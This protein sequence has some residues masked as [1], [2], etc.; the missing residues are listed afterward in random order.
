MK[1]NKFNKFNKFSTALKPSYKSKHF[2]GC[3]LLIGITA[4]ISNMFTM[5]AV[6]EILALVQD[7][8][9]GALPISTADDNQ[10]TIEKPQGPVNIDSKEIS[11]AEDGK[12]SPSCTVSKTTTSKDLFQSNSFQG[13]SEFVSVFCLVDFLCNF[14]GMT[15]PSS[16]ISTQLLDRIV[17]ALPKPILKQLP[18]FFRN[19]AHF[20]GEDVL[21]PPLDSSLPENNQIQVYDRVEI[22][23]SLN[24]IIGPRET[25]ASRV[26]VILIVGL[27]VGLAC[28]LVGSHG[29]L[30]PPPVT[31]R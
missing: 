25:L 15:E 11:V 7:Q 14:L 2:L 5:L 1:F 29:F 27:V 10:P 23:Q 18:T 17:K 3:I 26:T 21:P 4:F 9:S 28:G 6:R 16:S 12:S 19:A 24:N 30:E 13:F 8:I 22:P 20:L 31:R